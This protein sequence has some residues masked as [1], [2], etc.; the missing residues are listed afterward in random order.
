MK[1][2]E[3]NELT[4]GNVHCPR[5]GTLIKKE[6]EGF[7]LENLCEHVQFI[8]CDEGLE[9]SKD[10]TLFD[11]FENSDL[12]I[13]EFLSSKDCDKTVMISSFAPAP[14]FFGEYIGIKL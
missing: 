7:D 2:I 9:Y 14:S 10:N 6:N 1:N 13:G 11:K 3:L 5:C 4:N 8:A 12:E